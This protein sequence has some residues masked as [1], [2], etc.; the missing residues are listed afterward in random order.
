[1]DHFV[2]GELHLC[3]APPH[4]EL[5]QLKGKG[6][7]HAL[8]PLP[9]RG[10][11]PLVLLLLLATRRLCGGA[12]L[13]AHLD[14]VRQRVPFAIDPSDVVNQMTQ[15]PLMT[16]SLNEANSVGGQLF[17]NRRHRGAIEEPQ[18]AAIISVHHRCE[19]RAHRISDEADDGGDRTDELW[20]EGLQLVVQQRHQFAARDAKEVFRVKRV[21]HKLF[22]ARLEHVLEG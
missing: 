7:A 4:C 13:R 6:N 22:A 3:A 8:T 17:V 2:N 10:R 21:P 14:G 5:Q 12:E 11:G 19:Q 20:A 1:M 16:N 18:Q 9:Q 15:H